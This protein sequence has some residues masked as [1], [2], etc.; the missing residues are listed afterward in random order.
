MT[1]E[2]IKELYKLFA[3]SRTSLENDIVALEI[4]RL[5][6]YD[7]IDSDNFERLIP[8]ISEIHYVYKGMIGR[9]FIANTVFPVIYG[10]EFKFYII[11][12]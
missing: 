1:E 9:Y 5:H 12:I 6:L 2:K 8:G 11:P 7:V 4:D 10:N 3:D